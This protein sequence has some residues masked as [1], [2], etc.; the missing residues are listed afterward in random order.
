MPA[1]ERSLDRSR[2]FTVRET[3]PCVAE[4]LDAEWRGRPSH[5]LALHALADGPVTKG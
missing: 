5:G 3:E 2:L 1:R 4:I